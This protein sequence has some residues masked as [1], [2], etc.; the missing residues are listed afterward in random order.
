MGSAIKPSMSY[1]PCKNQA[2]VGID[3]GIKHFALLSNGSYIDTPKPLKQKLKRL[4][5]LSKQLSRKKGDTTKVSNNFKKD[6]LKLAKLH[7]KI[8]NIRKDF[9]HKFTTYLTDNFKYIS[10]ETLNVKGMIGNHKLS[11]AIS[12]I[13]MYEFKR[14]LKYKAKLKGN[15]I[16]ENDRWFASSKTCPNYGNVKKDLT[17]SDRIYECLECKKVKAD[18]DYIAYINLHNQLPKVHREVKPVESERSQLVL[19]AQ[20]NWRTALNL[21]A[22]VTDLSSI[23]E[24]GIKHQLQSIMIGVE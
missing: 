24:A 21:S 18:R 3:L 1:L 13:G 4:K 10:I 22:G 11:R 12:D 23:V 16:L 8:T 6:S 17:L 19:N 9:L 15:L 7:S 5:R 20:G 2:S 14:Q